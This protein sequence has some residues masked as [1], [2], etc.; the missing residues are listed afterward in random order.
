MGWS[1]AIQKRLQQAEAER[2]ALVVSKPVQVVPDMIPRLL[3]HYRE[4]LNDL[5]A[6]AREHPEQ[7]RQTVRDLVGEITV[8]EENGELW[9]EMNDPAEG[10]AQT[11][12]GKSTSMRMVAGACFVSHIRLRHKVR[13]A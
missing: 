6:I 5:A 7:A 11:L 12:L 9:A 3:D 13:A 10:V 8:T 2:R 1:E 4:E